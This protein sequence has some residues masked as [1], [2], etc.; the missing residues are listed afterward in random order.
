MFKPTFS[1]QW[2][3][4]YPTLQMARK[5]SNTDVFGPPV[6]LEIEGVF[7]GFTTGLLSLSVYEKVGLNCKGGPDPRKGPFKQAI[8]GGCT[9]MI[10]KY[11]NQCC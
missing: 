1:H 9:Q 7:S 6:G 11:Q 10:K 5:L 2:N 4:M 3:F 8:K